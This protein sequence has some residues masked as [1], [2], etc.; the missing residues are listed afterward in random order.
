MHPRGLNT[1]E[2]R[3]ALAR[4]VF[5]HRLGEICDRGFEQQRYRASGLTWQRS[6][7]CCGTPCTWSAPPTP[8]AASVGRSKK[9]CSNSCRR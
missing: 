4:A 1:G 2:A 7:L 8:C 6:P 5:F 9:R 3:N